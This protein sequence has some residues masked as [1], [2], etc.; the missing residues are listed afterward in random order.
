M[1]DRNKTFPKTDNI[2]VGFEVLTAVVMRM[3]TFWDIAPCSPFMNRRFRGT[4]YLLLHGRKSAEQEIRVGK[5]VR[6][7]SNG[8]NRFLRNIGS[9]GNYRVTYP[10]IWQLSNNVIV[11][12]T[13]YA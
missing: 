8:C 1:S 5:V 11:S 13:V 2:L 4:C 3:A 9:Y 10:R 12:G 7:C 6:Q